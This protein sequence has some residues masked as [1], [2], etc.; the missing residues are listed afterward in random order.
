MEG[1]GKVVFGVG[2]KN[3][4]HDMVP[5]L[6]GAQSQKGQSVLDFWL[7]TRIPRKAAFAL[8]AHL[9]TFIVNQIYEKL[10]CLFLM[11]KIEIKGCNDLFFII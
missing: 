5:P 4:S 9:T 8:F 11:Y 2:G 10:R 7:E 3:D 6:L 1:D